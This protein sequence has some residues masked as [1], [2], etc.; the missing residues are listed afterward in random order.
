MKM[1]NLDSKKR[2]AVYVLAAAVLGVCIFNFI[3]LPSINK[4]KINDTQRITLKSQIGD[5]TPL[6]NKINE[7][8][9]N[10]NSL[11]ANIDYI[12]SQNTDMTM[13]REEFLVFLGK[14]MNEYSVNMVKFS[15]LGTEEDNETYKSTY[16]L[17]MRGTFANLNNVLKMINAT[18]IRYS[19]CSLSLREDKSE[20]YLKRY[21]DDYTNLPWYKKAEPT[22]TPTPEPSPTPGIEPTPA[23]IVLPNDTYMYNGHIE[24]NNEILNTPEPTPT[25]E[26][27]IEPPEQEEPTENQFEN[28]SA[29]NTYRIQLLDNK[30]GMSF[31]D[32]SSYKKYEEMTLNITIQFVMYQNPNNS[33]NNVLNNFLNTAWNGGDQNAI[34]QL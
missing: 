21:F 12:K 22:P 4:I 8:T 11:I 5:M 2:I 20:E 29:N 19:V 6:D 34:L 7:L 3:I 16:D 17:Q 28:T 18:G 14:Y 26:P 31:D 33:E 9:E 32:F 1:K 25:P 27:A 30:N 15:D 13:N 24:Y 10:N 23:Q